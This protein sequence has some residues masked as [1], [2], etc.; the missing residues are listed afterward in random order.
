MERT[1]DRPLDAFA[2]LLMTF[3]C[4]IWGGAFVAIKVGLLDL[5]PLGSAAL[6]FLLTSVILFSWAR[7]TGVSLF[8]SAREMRVVLLLAA[9]FFYVNLMVYV[10]TARTTSGRATV[11]F[12]SQ[13]LFLAVLAAFLLP[14]DRVTVRK[15]WGL[16][17]AFLGL[18][19]LFLTKMS[20]GHVPT[21][22]G[23]AFVLSAAFVTA[24]QNLLMKRTAGRIHPVALVFWSSL[25]SGLLLSGGSW[26]F[27]HEASFLFSTR[28]VLSL[29][30]LSV[31]SAAFSFVA[32]AWL[33]QHYS[34]TRVNTL[35][36]L[37]PVFGVALSWLWLGETLTMVQ[38]A[39]VAGVCLGVYV[40]TSSAAPP[41]PPASSTETTTTLVEEPAVA[42]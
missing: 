8:Y 1:V 9:M 7:V 34:A 39:G 38:L 24:V 2:V 12:Y 22:L 27:E 36:F 21:L 17:L 10:G 23:D 31:V 28:A 37:A 40:V 33:L 11:F 3:V 13:P 32:F 5:P 41:L 30:Y 26:L 35:V 42:T 20:T 25:L 19:L 4:A 6:R 18:V 29:L 14:N 16:G 15:G